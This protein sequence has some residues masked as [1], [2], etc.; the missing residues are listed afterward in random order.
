M[1][2][3][4]S[5]SIINGRESPENEKKVAGFILQLFEMKES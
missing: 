5:W 1:Y 4:L 2:T 3:T